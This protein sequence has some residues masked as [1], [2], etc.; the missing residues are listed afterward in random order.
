MEWIAAD[1]A[2]FPNV[3]LSLFP[4]AL[5]VLDNVEGRALKSRQCHN[6]DSN[7]LPFQNQSRQKKL[8]K[9][10]KWK[11]VIPSN[12]PPTLLLTNIL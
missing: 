10:Q 1:L 8:A 9:S 6:D 5:A 4:P 3:C 7:K 11:K 2:I 12:I